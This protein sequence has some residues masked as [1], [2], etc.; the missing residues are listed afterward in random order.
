VVGSDFN[1]TIE[2]SSGKNQLSGL[3]GDDMIFGMAGGDQLK[4]G[5]GNDTL[6]G[7]AGSDRAIYDGDLAEYTL[8]RSAAKTVTIT[9]AT[10]GTDS[11]LDVEYFEFADQTINVWSLDIV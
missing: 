6:D 1:D 3:D 8:V 4:G 9:H 2:G 7:G 11:L 10:E 5:V